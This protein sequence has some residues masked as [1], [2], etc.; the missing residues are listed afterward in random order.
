MIH[1]WW[2]WRAG[3][4]GGGIVW[5]LWWETDAQTLPPSCTC[6]CYVQSKC[7]FSDAMYSTSLHC[8][9]VGVSGLLSDPGIPGV[10]SMGL[11][12]HLQLTLLRQ[13]QG[14]ARS[15]LNFREENEILGWYFFKKA[16]D[17]S[18]VLKLIC[19]FSLEK[20]K[21]FETRAIIS[22]FQSRV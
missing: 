15:I 4:G 16:V 5:S 20:F 17:F 2:C 14:M 19:I 12:V 18:S 6:C 3:V 13:N 1:W 8:W 11:F 22:S 10:R 7:F 9:P 21:C